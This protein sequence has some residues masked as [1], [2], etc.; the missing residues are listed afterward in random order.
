MDKKLIEIVKKYIGENTLEFVFVDKLFSS[1]DNNFYAKGTHA[2]YFIKKISKEKG[3]EIIE[4]FH[5][6]NKYY[7]RND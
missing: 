7:V 6:L 3:K 5:I 4:G 2:N 1:S